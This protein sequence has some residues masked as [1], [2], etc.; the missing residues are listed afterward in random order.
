MA[1]SKPPAPAIFPATLQ[2]MKE[3]E[4]PGKKSVEDVAAFLNLPARQIVKTILLENE[5]GLV[6]GLVRGDH[7]INPVKLKNLIG[8]EWL[9]HA[10]ERT[11]AK[12]PEL[13]CGYVGPVGLDLPVYADCEIS[14]MHDFVTGANK[15]STH[16]TGA[17]VE[18]DLKVKQFSDIRTV[19]ADDPC[20]RCEGGKY[21]VKRGIE[22]GHI[23]IL[24]TKYSS[25]MKAVFLDHQ[26]KENAIIM[27]CY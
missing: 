7:E 12:H 25:A 5:H 18:R 8:C 19:K 21:Q 17:Q 4:T 10:E 9:Q 27:C 15:P 20:P 3:V 24:G 23:F 11:I 26:G 6:A 14:A 2:E 22:V 13:H 1:E 16:F